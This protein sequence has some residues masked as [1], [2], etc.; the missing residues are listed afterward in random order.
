MSTT[1]FNIQLTGYLTIVNKEVKRIFRIWI[2]TLLPSVV[3][4]SL[5][6]LVF[7]SFIGDRIGMIGEF[8]YMQFIVPGLIMMSVILNSYN[9]VVS[10]VF[11]SKFQKSIEELLISP[12]Y[13]ST[14][15]L[16][17]ISSG[18]VRGTVVGFLVML[19]SL[20]FVPFKVAHPLLMLATLLLTSTFFSLCGCIAALFAKNFDHMTIV[21]TFILTPLIYLGGI[22]YS[23]STL[24]QFWQNISKFNPILYLINTFRYSFLRSK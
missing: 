12:L 2:Q 17:W 22:F 6:F 9:N 18:V 16:G 1:M 13:T 14:I 4:T 8:T 7:G 23:I 21:P 19:V 24:P 3:T 20:W 5:Y 11:G 15:I 10:V